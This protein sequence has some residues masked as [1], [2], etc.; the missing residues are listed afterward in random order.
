MIAVPFAAAVGLVAAGCGGSSSHPNSSASTSSTAPSTTAA[1]PAPALSVGQTSLG[2]ILTDA[3][4]RSVYLFEKDTGT[5][6]T[7]LDACV[8]VWPPATTTDAQPTVSG[9]ANQSLVG[10]TM[11]PDGTRQLTYAGHP[12]YRYAGDQKPGDTTGEGLNSFGAGWDVLSPAGNKIEKG[13]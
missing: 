10:T 7:C 9:G 6:S 12:V 3:Q 5:A 13:G 11:R 1:P 2:M 4:G 8:A